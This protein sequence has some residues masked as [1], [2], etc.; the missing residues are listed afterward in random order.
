MVQKELDTDNTS[1]RLAC[2]QVQRRGLQRPAIP[3]SI[4]PRPDT[5][6]FAYRKNRFVSF[7][8]IYWQLMSLPHLLFFS[9]SKTTLPLAHKGRP[10]LLYPEGALLGDGNGYIEGSELDGFLKEFVSSVNTNDSGSEV[11]RQVVAGTG[12]VSGRPFLARRSG[13]F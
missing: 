9:V 8:C 6:L 7:L 10:E 2:R 4:L 3:P 5:T 11:S 1:Q 13:C 12:R